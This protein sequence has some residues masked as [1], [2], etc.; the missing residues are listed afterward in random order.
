MRNSENFGARITKNG[1]SDR[2]IWYWEFWR[3]KWSF[4]TVLGVFVEFFEWWE[5]LA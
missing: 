5:A 3:V 4:H 2:K 1:T